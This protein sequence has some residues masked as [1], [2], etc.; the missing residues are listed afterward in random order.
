MA[1]AEPTERFSDRVNDY[2]KYR[3]TYP[4]E[5]IDRIVEAAELLPG[6]V[7]ADVGCGTGISS[8][9]FLE[10]GIRVIG[11]EPN[12]AM[13]A[14]AI[15]YLA[16]FP[17]FTANA[18]SAESTGVKDHSVDAIIAAQA[19]H[20]FDME[21]TRFEFER[22]LRP[23][24]SVV[25]M[26]NERLLDATEFLREYEE[27]L[28]KYAID[29]SE[30][31]HDRFGPEKLRAFFGAPLKAYSFKN[32]QSFDL[33]GMVGRVRSSSFMPAADSPVYG[34]LLDSLISLF[35][36]HAENDRIEIFYDTRVYISRF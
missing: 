15:E 13:R 18:A 33:D 32:M 8:R 22:I 31:R 29:Y 1:A 20:W 16:G 17:H 24:G 34:E 9:P 3:P 25:L 27:L 10:R 19:F 35:A 7:I 26:W 14:A 21:T 11:V 30:I 2:V 36:K 28:V 5:A 6:S 12:D 4:D 23:G